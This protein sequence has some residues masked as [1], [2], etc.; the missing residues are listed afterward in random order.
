MLQVSFGSF[1][2]LETQ[3]L[4]LRKLI[5][6]DVNELFNLRSQEQ[7]MKYIARPL[8]KN[9][10]DIYQ[11]IQAINRS[12]D[13]NEGITWAIT[14]KDQPQLI[15]TIGFWRIMKEHF[16]AEVGYMLEPAFHNQGIMHEALAAALDFG[17][18]KLGLHSVEANISPE[19]IASRQLVAKNN[20]VK[21]AHFKE[22]YYYNGVFLDSV[23]YSLITPLK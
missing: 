23:I 10:A 14:L 22:N 3:R 1:P 18:S 12:F 15:G 13:E 20:F 8:P 11:L 17:F 2:V 4:R 21:E 16:R 9:K 5:D 19:N 6:T 7:V